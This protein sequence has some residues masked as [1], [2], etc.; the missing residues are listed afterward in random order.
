MKFDRLFGYAPFQPE[1][2]WIERESMGRYDLWVLFVCLAGSLYGAYLLCDL[3]I[4]RKRKR[5]WKL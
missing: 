2:V 4:N 1:H 5:R 3:T